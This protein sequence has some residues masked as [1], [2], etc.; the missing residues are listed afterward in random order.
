MFVVLNR[1]IRFLRSRWIGVTK[2]APRGHDPAQRIFLDTHN[3]L[4]WVYGKNKANSG[5]NECR[6]TGRYLHVA[7]LV[8]KVVMHMR[9]RAAGRYYSA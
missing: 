2:C 9:E 5:G 8:C 6:N 3:V 1:S 4:F 7:Y